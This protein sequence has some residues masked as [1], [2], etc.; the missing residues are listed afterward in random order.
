MRIYFLIFIDDSDVI[1]SWN[2]FLSFLQLFI[3]ICVK[4][5]SKIG[6]FV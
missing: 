4:Y 6:T 2:K 5:V 1:L 3:T